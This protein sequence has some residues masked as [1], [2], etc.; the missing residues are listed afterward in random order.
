MVCRG[1]GSPGGQQLGLGG[2]AFNSEGFFVVIEPLD[3]DFGCCLHGFE[4]EMTLNS[5]RTKIK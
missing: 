5:L 1:V 3:V 2:A 4:F